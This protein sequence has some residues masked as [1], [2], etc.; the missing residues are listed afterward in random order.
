MFIVKVQKRQYLQF[1][2]WPLGSPG[3]P[4]LLWVPD[5]ILAPRPM[6]GPQVLGPISPQQLQAVDHEEA[7]RAAVAPVPSW[8][9]RERV[10]RVVG[11]TVVEGWRSCYSV[12]DGQVEE[13]EEGV[14]MLSVCGNIWILY[15]IWWIIVRFWFLGRRLLLPC[16]LFILLIRTFLVLAF[17]QKIAFVHILD[18]LD[19]MQCDLIARWLILHWI[20]TIILSFI[21]SS[22][23]QLTS[24]VGLYFPLSYKR[25]TVLIQHLKRKS[26]EVNDL[27]WNCKWSCEL[28]QFRRNFSS[29]FW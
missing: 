4:P 12:L 13:Q 24:S 23:R 8:D 11:L 16:I 18:V 25:I 14:W 29:K 22:I 27:I 10:E 1:I 5:N 9:I 3:E 26:V 28:L 2:S 7:A 17:R 6:D 20:T 15:N 21:S 19:Q